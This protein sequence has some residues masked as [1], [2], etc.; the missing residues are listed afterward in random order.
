MWWAFVSLHEGIIYL[1]KWRG[2]AELSLEELTA[3]AGSGALSA[4]SLYRVENGIA[5][6]KSLLL[7]R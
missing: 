1:N 3:D 7:C 4:D 5:S 2:G 6:E